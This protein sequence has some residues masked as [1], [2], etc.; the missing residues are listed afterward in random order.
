LRYFSSQKEAKKARTELET[1]VTG[2]TYSDESHKVTVSIIAKRWRAADYSPTRTDVLRS[3]TSSDYE[4][5]LNKYVLPRWGAVRLIDIRAG[6]VEIWRND[7]IK[8]GVGASTVRKALLV[9]GI[10]FRFAMR[11]H[12]V[13]HDPTAHVKKPTV[14][15][16]KEKEERLTPEQLGKLFTVLKGCPRIIVRVAAGTGMR[17]GEIFGLQ[18]KNVDLKGRMILVE[19]QYTHGEFVPH[20]KTDA[21][22]RQ[23]GID[24]KLAA[25]LSEWKLAQKPEHRRDESLV[26]GNKAGGPMSAAFF[27]A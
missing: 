10:L 23:I 18:W 1:R 3:T 17:E 19:R 9:L 25:E 13:T 15:K 14:R 6:M 12:I 5:L 22:Y 7:L 27:T 26:C 16:R 2:G 24:A 21:G 4:L 8:D 20:A 11:D